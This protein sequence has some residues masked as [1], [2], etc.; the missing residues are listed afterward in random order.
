MRPVSVGLIPTCSSKQM[1][2]YHLDMLGKNQMNV[3]SE[4]TYSLWI[5]KGPDQLKVISLETMSS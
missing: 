2:T 5:L 1:D 3:D 4:K